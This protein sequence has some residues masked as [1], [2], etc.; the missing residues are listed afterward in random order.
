M[1]AM[2]DSYVRNDCAKNLSNE[3]CAKI[4]PLKT[5]QKSIFM[6]M[7][8]IIGKKAE[9]ACLQQNYNHEIII[10]TAYQEKI[11]IITTVQD[12]QKGWGPDL[13]KT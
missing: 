2:V 9:L 6:E 4:F 7:P 1:F 11:M 12:Y 8:K 5:V 10:T 13:A 3:N